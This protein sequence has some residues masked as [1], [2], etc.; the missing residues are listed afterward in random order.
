[1]TLL[2]ARAFERGRDLEAV[3]A[4][5]V[6]WRVAGHLDEFLTPWRLRLLVTSRLWDARNAR[7]WE[8][9]AERLVA[10]CA[11]LQRQPGAPGLGLEY[12]A[13]PGREEPG[14]EPGEE[15]MAA[16]LGWAGLWS[17]H[18]RSLWSWGGT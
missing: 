9:G 10:F 5:L 1:M 12:V 18:E 7:V 4:L 6:A 8:D 2:R 11:L 17:A 16:A 15:V 14:E 13:R 3:V